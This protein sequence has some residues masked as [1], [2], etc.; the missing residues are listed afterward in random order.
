MPLIS[1]AIGA[2]TSLRRAAGGIGV[3]HAPCTS[4]RRIPSSDLTGHIRG[5]QIGIV[6][7][8]FV[9]NDAEELCDRFARSVS[10]QVSYFTSLTVGI[11]CR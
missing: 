5:R 8:F 6:D 11:P 9:T 3:A 1:Y 4:S 2:R 7:D 10:T